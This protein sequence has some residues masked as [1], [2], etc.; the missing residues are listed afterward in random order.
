MVV[1]WVNC[2][3]IQR[4][5]HILTKHYYFKTLELKKNTN[6]YYYTIAKIVK[7]ELY[8]IARRLKDQERCHVMNNVREAYI[9]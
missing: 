5:F 3:E 2:V 8:D 9:A 4:I 1:L 6:S 7:V